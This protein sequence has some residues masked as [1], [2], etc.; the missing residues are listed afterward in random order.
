MSLW[1]VFCD[2][3][4]IRIG[5]ILFS[6]SDS[7]IVKLLAGGM[8]IIGIMTIPIFIYLFFDTIRSNKNNENKSETENN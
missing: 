8:C 2:A 3:L 7:I 4:T 6:R 1:V 5:Y